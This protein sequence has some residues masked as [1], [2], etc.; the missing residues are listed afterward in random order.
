MPKTEDPWDF[1]I[2]LDRKVAPDEPESSA[3]TLIGEVRLTTQDPDEAIAV[4]D[5]LRSRIGDA[6][7][8]SLHSLETVRARVLGAYTPPARR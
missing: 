1:R 8:V 3:S 2:Q 7:T 4:R 6:Y 5:L